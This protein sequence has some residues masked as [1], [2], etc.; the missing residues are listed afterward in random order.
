VP[1]YTGS[2]LASW[3]SY[4]GNGFIDGLLSGSQWGDGTASSATTIT[5][6]FPW[7]NGLSAFFAYTGDPTDFPTAGVTSQQR[8]DV[9]GAFQS[10]SNVANVNFVEVAEDSA[11]NVGDIRFAFSDSV[12][13]YW[14]WAY[15]P[16]NYP[17]GGDIWVHTRY[18]G[19]S[20]GPGTYNFYASVHEIGHAL[21]LD[22]SFDGSFTIPAGFDD[23]RYTVMSYTDPADAWWFNEATGQ[24]EYLIRGP[25]VYDILAIQHLYGANMSY[26]AG[27]S[28]YVFDESHPFITALWDAG[29][30]DLLDFR[31][32][33]QGCTIDLTPGSYSTTPFA[34]HSASSNLGIAFNCILENVYCGSGDDRVV[35][36]S[37]ANR[38]LG[39]DG[40]D[41]LRGREGNDVLIGGAGNDKLDGGTGINRLIGGA[42]N[43]RLINGIADYDSAAAAVRADLAAGSAESVDSGDAARIGTDLLTN[44]QSVIGSD[45]ADILFGNSL[46]CSMYGGAGADTIV[47]F[48]G[49]DLLDGGSGIDQL[50]G[51]SGDDRYVIDTRDDVIVEI[52]AGGFDTVLCDFSFDLSLCANVEGLELVGSDSISGIGNNLANLLTGNSAANRLTGGGGND[53]LD[54]GAGLDKMFGGIGNDIYIVGDATDYAYEYA[55]EGVDAVRSTISIALR[56]NVENL[57]LE[58]TSNI[59]GR[60]N[61]LANVVIGNDGSNKLNGM[62]GD[63]RLLSGGGN[64]RIE[65]GAGIDRMY[66]GVGNDT[67]IV[68]DSTDYAYENAGEGVDVALASVSVT[69][70]ANVDR[71]ILTGSNAI[72]GTGNADANVLTGNGAAN[73]LS[74]LL[75]NDKL[76][77][78]AGDDAVSG[79][80]GADIIDGGAGRDRL[81]GGAGSDRFMFNDGDFAGLTNSTCDQIKDF[82]HT[83]RDIIRVSAI[84]ADTTRD[85]NQAFGF[86][87]GDAFHGTAGELRFEQISG[88]TYVQGDT[89]GDGVADFWIRGDG[90]HTLAAADFIF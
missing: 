68:T 4:S 53:T 19:D 78:G 2:G 24:S 49:A 72:N 76:F 75:G 3:S 51:G 73:I 40:V 35:G 77:A 28:T 70:R 1:Y 48:G 6:S 46:D 31:D 71:L 74:G 8:A 37:A 45:F 11:G 58:G 44:V 67:Y 22:H 81:F 56:A 33:T 42:G 90:L 10:W 18:T 7:M 66:G 27:D 25:M 30:I 29:G 55:G 16:G 13:G 32:F 43:D 62:A 38:I 69:L 88:N 9:L 15:Y 86:I 20:F 59:W 50:D 39:G 82:S 61:E 87:G 47:T 60:G 54:G 89:D 84:D 63:D 64:D 41:V 79:G 34:N 17:Q 83:D 36:N 65:G 5:F 57:T 23:R 26:E 12:G 80:D 21:G 14:G 52:L 85:G